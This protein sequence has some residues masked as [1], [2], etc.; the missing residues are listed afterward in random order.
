SEDL[1]QLVRRDGFQLIVSAVCRLLI[2]PP[3]HKRGGVPEAIAL[4]VV[5]FHFADAF[6]AER[7][8]REIFS[9]APTALAPWHACGLS[10]ARVG[11]FAPRMAI[12]RVLTKRLE[13][14]RQLLAP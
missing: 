13:F 9:S 2:L 14:D 5:V 1:L 3:A 10:T 7:L 6:D 8:P 4:Q 11:P 12:E